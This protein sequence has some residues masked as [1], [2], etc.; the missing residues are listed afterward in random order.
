MTKKNFRVE[1][2]TLNISEIEFIIYL[3]TH[4]INIVRINISAGGCG[5]DVV[6]FAAG[7]R[8]ALEEMIDL[9][10]KDTFL[11]SRIRFCDAGE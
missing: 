9:F 1:L 10:Y 4:K 8:T 6:T 7:T 5:S 3:A 2:D 11:Y